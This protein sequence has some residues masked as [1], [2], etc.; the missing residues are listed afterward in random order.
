MKCPRGC[1]AYLQAFAI[2]VATILGTGIL[3]LPVELYSSGLLPFIFI[4]IICL[5]MQISV[6]YLMVELLQHSHVALIAEKLGETTLNVFGDLRSENNYQKNN[7]IIINKNNKSNNDTDVDKPDLHRIG[8]LFLTNVWLARTFDFAVIL[9]FM[10]VLISYALAGPQAYAD[11]L[12]IEDYHVLIVPYTLIYTLFIL[13]SGDYIKPIISILT[14]LKMLALICVLFA[15]SVVADLINIESKNDFSA[16]LEPFLM[17]TFALGGVVNLMPVMYEKLPFIFDN[18]NVF[19]TQQKIFAKQENK[20]LIQGFRISITLGVL[21]C[22][23]LN[24]LWC[25]FVLQI[26]PQTN[27]YNI[28]VNNNNNNNN[29][30]NQKYNNYTLENCYHNGEISTIPVV[31]IIETYF[32]A[33]RWTIFFIDGFVIVSITVS[34]LT[35]GKGLKHVLDGI[36]FKF[37]TEKDANESENNNISADISSINNNEKQPF[38]NRLLSVK[39]ILYII[40]FGIILI[41]ALLNPQGF[42]TMLSVFGSFAL[43]I[44]C[45]V[46]VSLMAQE[47]KSNDKFVNNF[48]PLKISNNIAM[49]LIKFAKYTFSFAILYDWFTCG[50]RFGIDPILWYI[51]AS[52]VFCIFLFTLYFRKKAFKKFLGDKDENYKVLN[53]ENDNISNNN[54]NNNKIHSDVNDNVILDSSVENRSRNTYSAP[55]I[56]NSSDSEL[57]DVPI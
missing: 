30:E 8:R 45:G 41:M 17:G 11:L 1:Y 34:F 26:V 49:N 9:H 13:L 24:I 22:F 18:G 40:G 57:E 20:K 33:Y 32:P 52:I 50:I 38:F 4:F 19:T 48:I 27:D 51:I 16:A 14:I 56:T 23:L 3:A 43:N 42:L 7:N 44:E 36:S 55:T 53:D 10:A 12:Q 6:V 54:N 31:H 37:I 21:A 25:L 15:V 2:T 35:L 5:C 46:F 47:I 29:N 28:A 39:I